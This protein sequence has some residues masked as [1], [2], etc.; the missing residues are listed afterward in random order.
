M[1]GE[2]NIQQN[3]CQVQHYTTENK[4]TQKAIKTNNFI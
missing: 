2:N 1:R 3:Y 4:S